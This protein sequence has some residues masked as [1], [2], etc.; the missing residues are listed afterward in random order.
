MVVLCPQV[1]W[2]PHTSQQCCA[3]G[4]VRVL[5]GSLRLSQGLSQRWVCGV[6]RGR[7]GGHGTREG[8]GH[9]VWGVVCR[10]GGVL[11]RLTLFVCSLS[12][13]R[14]RLLMLLPMS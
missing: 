5:R 1:S 8:W 9:G 11:Q 2:S 6:A 10:V 4:S 13:V 14:Y 12:F 3:V 7:E